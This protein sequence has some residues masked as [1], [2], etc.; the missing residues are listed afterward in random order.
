MRGNVYMFDQLPFFPSIGDD[1][2]SRLVIK[3]YQFCVAHI[4]TP[5]KEVVPILTM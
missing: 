5:L 4:C 2:E 1:K 3:Y